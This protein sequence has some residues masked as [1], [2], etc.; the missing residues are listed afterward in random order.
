VLRLPAARWSVGER[1]DQ[2]LRTGAFSILLLKHRNTG[3]AAELKHGAGGESLV[4][5][6]VLRA[7]CVL[8]WRRRYRGRSRA[9]A[10]L[11]FNAF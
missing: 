1:K 2:S 5:D 3:R 9:A 7:W 6:S 4:Y 10:T 11:S 8:P